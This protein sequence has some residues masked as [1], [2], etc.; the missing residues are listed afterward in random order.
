VFKFGEIIEKQKVNNMNPIVLAFVGDAVYS[1]FVREKLACNTDCKSGELNKLATAKVNA[2]AQ[3]NFVKE[4]S[5]LFTEEEIII[6]KRARN[7][8][9]TTKAKNASVAEYN[10]ATGFEAVL[11]YLYLIGNFE[12]LNFILNKGMT[13]EN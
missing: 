6:F 7:A 12:R 13:N 5:N 8:K 2:S 11:G 3:A 1:L 9:K 4:Y 10:V